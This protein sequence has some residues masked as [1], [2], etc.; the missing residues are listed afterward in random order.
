AKA[1]LERLAQSDPIARKLQQTAKQRGSVKFS[2]VMEPARSFLSA[3]IARHVQQTV[4]ILCPS[5]RAQD[6]VYE[7]L[8]NWLPNGEFLPEAEFA[9]VENILPDLEIAAERLALL[10]KID[11][12]PGPHVIVTTRASLEQRAPKRGAVPAAT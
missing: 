8:L 5:V 1:L 7:T 6:S 9:A 11:C 2:H 3:V 10:A 4:W 12:E